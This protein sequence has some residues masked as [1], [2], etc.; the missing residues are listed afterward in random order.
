MVT[1]KTATVPVQSAPN[2]KNVLSLF[3]KLGKEKGVPAIELRQKENVDF[4]FSGSLTLS[5]I[6][7]GG[8]Y[9]GQV[10]QIYGPPGVGK[11]TLVYS[12][13]AYLHKLGI[14]TTFFDHEGTTDRAYIETLG[15]DASNKDPLLQYFRPK[16]GNDTYE[17]LI[18]ALEQLPDK[19]F[20][21]PQ[22]VVFI[23]SVATMA[24]R[25]EFELEESKRPAVRASMHS[26]F[27]GMLKGTLTRKHVSLVATNQ[28]RSNVG[29]PYQSNESVPGGNAW[30][31]ST[32]NLVRIG[33]G[34]QVELPDGGVFQLVRFKT[35][36]NKNF[37]PMQEGEIYL[38]L[39][40]GFDPASDAISFA[41]M[42]GY[43]TKATSNA[44]DKTIIVAGLDKFNY[45]LV[46]K[47]LDKKITA[48]K[49]KA[50]FAASMKTVEEA[51][52]AKEFTKAVKALCALCGVADLALD[53]TYSSTAALEA[54][55]RKQRDDGTNMFYNACHE[56]LKD[57]EAVRAYRTSRDKTKSSEDEDVSLTDQ[58][59]TSKGSL[60]AEDELGDE[61]GDDAEAEVDTEAVS[62]AE[63]AE[64]TVP[65][66]KK[67]KAAP[68]PEPE[69]PE[70]AVAKKIGKQ[71]KKAAE[72]KEAP[73]KKAKRG[74]W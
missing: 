69:E 9:G 65:A 10:F 57:G 56:S 33:R 26:K 1:K 53:G 19:S 59:K 43:L 11:S 15:M 58:K 72:P 47:L 49:A 22:L 42:A 67:P 60:H 51:V 36:K 12:A 32:D 52:K 6:M 73:K 68:E 4:L 31:F 28:V 14:P 41:K 21:L 40:H 13:A 71:R 46:R 44:K 54:L 25:K 17:M 7:G 64:P 61:S 2:A 45:P 62:E 37:I 55:I 66:A 30:Q 3:G 24:E 16:S 5:L 27:W 74:G 50:N 38:H 70:P 35:H 34:K 39:G 20:G 48:V 18:E 29:N 63:D 23:D 8:Y